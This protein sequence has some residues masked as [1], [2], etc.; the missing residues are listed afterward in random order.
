MAS[1]DGD[2]DKRLRKTSV[3]WNYFTLV[4]DEK[5]I[6]ACNTCDSHMS[7]RS[8]ISNLMKH[9]KR[10]HGDIGTVETKMFEDDK[11]SDSEV[12]EANKVNPED[13]LQC[14]PIQE[15]FEITNA[16]KKI[17]TC[18]VCQVPLTYKSSVTILLRHLRRKHNIDVGDVEL[19]EDEEKKPDCDSPSPN[20]R[21]VI[22]P[23]FRITDPAC[24]AARCLVCRKLLSYNTGTSNLRKHLMRKHPLINLPGPGEERKTIILSS[25]DQ[26]YEYEVE[27]A[28][29]EHKGVENDDNDQSEPVAID[30]VFLDEFNGS[31]NQMSSD[32]KYKSKKRKHKDKKPNVLEHSDSDDEVILKKSKGEDSIDIFGKY[33]ASLLKELPKQ[34]S[35]RLQ[36]EFVKQIMNAQLE[37]QNGYSEPQSQYSITIADAGASVPEDVRFEV[38]TT[39]PEADKIND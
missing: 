27:A 5:R 15:H 23:Y 34:T 33:I 28:E 4:D 8:S 36:K 16:E 13:K 9:L 31:I 10:K 32:K 29:G 22:W 1:R 30:E 39:K 20:L 24:K 35:N 37:C 21:S 26:L 18:S 2:A 19:S 6:A 38:I 11:D 25:G 7:F 14:G 3:A 17:A 12:D